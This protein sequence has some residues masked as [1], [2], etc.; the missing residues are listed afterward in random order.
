MTMEEV[1]Y[2]SGRMMIVSNRVMRVFKENKVPVILYTPILL[3]SNQEEKT[4]G[5]L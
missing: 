2:H 5:I 3:I 4:Y 1:I